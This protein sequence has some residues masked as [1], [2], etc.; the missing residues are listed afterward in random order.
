MLLA[1][2]CSQPAGRR[3]CRLPAAVWAA[4][5]TK[6]CHARPTPAAGSDTSSQPGC[7]ARAACLVR[8]CSGSQPRSLGCSPGQD[9]TGVCI[10]HSTAHQSCAGLGPCLPACTP[11]HQLP[12]C[13][14]LHC[15]AKQRTLLLL[16]LSGLQ[17]LIAPAAGCA[18]VCRLLTQHTTPAGCGG[19]L[20]AH[21]EVALLDMPWPACQAT[22]TVR[23][24]QPM[25][26]PMAELLVQ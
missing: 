23:K 20:L 5:S 2:T 10:P 4:G 19:P 13:L 14:C 9:A 18:S 25:P 1:C 21:R 26:Q 15:Q 12:D 3:R 16:L 11:A 22:S 7:G 17:L 6:Q 8:A 24:Y